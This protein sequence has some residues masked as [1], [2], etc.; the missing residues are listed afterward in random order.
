MSKTKEGPERKELYPRPATV[1]PDRIPP[2]QAAQGKLAHLSPADLIKLGALIQ[3][4]FDMGPGF[5]VII[6]DYHLNTIILHLND[7]QGNN[8][9]SDRVD[10]VEF[11]TDQNQRFYMGY[12]R[13][14][15]TLAINRS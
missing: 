14:L 4:H 11:R 13:K 15:N 8:L 2:T 3:K 6:D 12:S 7:S 5:E 9:V 10:L 1:R